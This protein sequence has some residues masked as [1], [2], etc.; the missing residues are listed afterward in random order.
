MKLAR[1]NRRSRG[2]IDENRTFAHAVKGT[3]FTHRHLA[4]IIIIADTSKDN[5]RTA[6]GFLGCRGEG[7]A[8]SLHPGLCLRACAIIDRNV[9]ASAREM[10]RHW[11]AH[12]A[13]PDECDLAHARSSHSCCFYL[14]GERRAAQKY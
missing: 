10:A 3:G 7:T 9:V 2:V 4:Q 11:K 5:F 12:H 14:A 13:K 8:I 1:N 6:R